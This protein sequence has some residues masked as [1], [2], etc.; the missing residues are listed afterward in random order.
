MTNI[1]YV[2]QKQ[3]QTSGGSRKENEYQV[4]RRYYQSV[5]VGENGISAVCMVLPSCRSTALPMC[6]SGVSV[7]EPQ[8]PEINL[9]GIT[10]T[11]NISTWPWY[12]LDITSSIFTAHQG[13]LVIRECPARTVPVHSPYNAGYGDHLLGRPIHQGRLNRIF[14]VPHYFGSGLACKDVNSNAHTRT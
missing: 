10:Q 12:F 3:T 6:V 1:V 11:I 2:F 9:P 8:L 4:G 13:V 7:E 14:C 5:I